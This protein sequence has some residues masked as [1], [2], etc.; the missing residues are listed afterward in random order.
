MNT[1]DLTPILQA[2]IGLLA[3]L[4]TCRL[5]PWLKSK[6]TETQQRVMDAALDSAVYAAEQFY[7]AGHGADK[8]DYALN[9]LHERGFDV[10]AAQIEAKVYELLNRGKHLAVVPED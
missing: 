5:I 8:M 6:M 7:G 1:I 2:L 9:F 3:T 4:I 10:D